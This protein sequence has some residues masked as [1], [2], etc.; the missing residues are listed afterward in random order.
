MKPLILLF[1]CFGVIGATGQVTQIVIT[2]FEGRDRTFHRK[3]ELLLEVNG[4]QNQIVYAIDTA[5]RRYV[6]RHYQIEKF[7]SVSDLDATYKKSRTHI[8]KR[9]KHTI[10]ETELNEISEALNTDL[11]SLKKDK[12]QVIFHTSHHSIGIHIDVIS[13]SDTVSYT[14]SKP[15]KYS[16]PWRKETQP[17]TV[18][19]PVIDKLI[20]GMLPE[21]FLGRQLLI[22]S[23][24]ADVNEDE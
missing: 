6:T 3:E 21:K 24:E 22:L 13:G 2:A 4:I 5:G 10:S 11:D 12:R 18:L 1:F 15:F 17:Y 16:T 20:A 23:P 9:W 14:K 8:S 19:N 7:H